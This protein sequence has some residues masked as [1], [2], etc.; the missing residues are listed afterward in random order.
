[1]EQTES[2]NYQRENKI[3]FGIVADP[4]FVEHQTKAIE[5]FFEEYD[6]GSES[7]MPAGGKEFYAW[8]L[9][10]GKHI[11]HCRLWKDYAKKED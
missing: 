9:V 10:P 1:M 8:L 2:G 5:L 7:P 11:L 6:P 3:D 4:R